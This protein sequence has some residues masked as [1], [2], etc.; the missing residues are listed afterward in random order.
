MS[1]RG[2]VHGVRLDHAP[3]PVGAARQLHHDVDGRADLIADRV[4]RNHTSLIDASVS[5]RTI[6][7]SAELACTVTSEPS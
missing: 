6:A 7:S 2:G 4:E 5:S 1:R 3:V